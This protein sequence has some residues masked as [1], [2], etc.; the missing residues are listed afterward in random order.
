MTTVCARDGVLAG[1]G[2][3]CDEEMVVDRKCQK[4]FRLPDGRLVGFSGHSEQAH[5]LLDAMKNKLAIPRLEHC[6]GLMVDTKGAIWLYEGMV[7]RRCRVKFYAI[8]SGAYFAM[9]AMKAGAD[10]LKACRIGA[11]MDPSSGGL[12][13]WL[14]VTKRR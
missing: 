8:G 5:V 12:V 11:D 14:S 9:A 3:E 1:D 7:W 13:R 10:A 4:V 6:T 2:L